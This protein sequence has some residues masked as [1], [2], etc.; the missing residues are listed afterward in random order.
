MIRL[1]VNIDHV[2]TLRQARYAGAGE[3]A[4]VEPDLLEAAREAQKGGAD[5]ITV[6]L[7]E[8]RRHIQDRDVFRLS[9]SISIPL[10]LELALVPEIVLLALRLKPQFTCLV[11]EKRQEITTEG[12]LDLKP[13][14]KD[15]QTTIQ[16]L[17]DAGIRVSIFL[18]PDRDQIKTAALLGADA[19]ELHTGK[20]ALAST[21]GAIR[22]EVEKLKTSAQMAGEE[23]L[24]VNAGHGIN[25]KNVAHLIDL[26][27][28]NEFNIGHSIVSRA[29]TTGLQE[30]VRDMKKIMSRK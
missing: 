25:Y 17:H 18:D 27:Y 4:W 7:R 28:L 12:G 1:G 16:K 10:N 5:G 13:R 9:E 24:L 19:I 6:H 11:P 23:G 15:C 20:F 21:P 8:D 2:A 22:R 26:P 29:V 3:N 30:A 14:K